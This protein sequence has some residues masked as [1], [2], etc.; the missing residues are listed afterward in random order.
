VP[1]HRLPKSPSATYSWD[2]ETN[3]FT[4][5]TPHADLAYSDGAA[6]EERLL[7]LV[8]GAADRSLHSAE[9]AAAIEDWPTRYHLHAGRANLLRPLAARLAGRTLEIGAGCG[10]LTRY[11]GEL[12]GDV[13]AVEGSRLRA[14]IAAA[15]CLDLPNVAVVH[16]LAERFVAD[17][18]FSAVTLVGVLEWATRFGDGADGAR[19][20]LAHVAT[21]LDPDGTL[22]VAIENQ[23]G[24]KYMAGWPEDHLG[25]PMRGVDD[26]YRP[27]EPRTYGIGELSALL[28]SAGLTRQ[29]VF[30][31][32]PDYK[33]PRVV[34]SPRG[35]ADAQWAS[36]LAGLVS[37]TPASDPQSPVFPVFSLEQSLALAAR[38]GVLTG[39]ANSFLV[40]ASRAPVA[41]ADESEVLTWHFSGGR[42]PAFQTETRF[43]ATAAGIA[44]ERVPMA[45][46]TTPPAHAPIRQAQDATDFV[47]GQLW[48]E[49][50]GP[51]IN[52][53][54]WTVAEVAAWSEP[55]RRAL[56]AAAGLTGES[57]DAV[58]P[59]RLLDATPFN[60]AGPDDRLGF[61]DLEWEPAWPVEYGFVVFRGLFWSLARLRSI[62]SGAANTPIGV[63]ALTLEVLRVAG[64]L[65]TDAEAERYLDLEAALQEQTSTV[66]ASAA[67]AALASMMVLPRPPLS[68]VA[69]AAGQHFRLQARATALEQ[70]WTK[71]ETYAKH[72]EQRYG[73]SESLSRNLEQQLAGMERDLEAVTAQRDESWEKVDRLEEGNARLARQLAEVETAHRD[74]A[75]QLRTVSGKC[76]NL[77]NDLA[78]ARALEHETAAKLQAREH[79]LR[80]ER[81]ALERTRIETASAN[82]RMRRLAAAQGHAR[83]AD[84]TSPASRVRQRL[85]DAD[86]PLGMLVRHPARFARGVVRLRRQG[87]RALVAQLAESGLFDR[88]HYRR[89]SGAGPHVN[90][91][92]R[93]LLGGDLAGES[94]HPLFDPSWYRA[95]YPDLD[96]T[97]PPLRHYLSAGGWELRIP[98]PLFDPAHYLAQWP[99][100]G[101]RA[102]TPLSHYVL[103]GARAAASPHPLFDT[104][105]YL[106]QRPELADAGVDPLAH[107]LAHGAEEGLDP[108]PLFSTRHY[109][110]RYPEVGSANPLA[111]FIERGAANGC[112]PHPLFD[113]AFYWEQRP[114]VRHHG[115][116]ALMHFLEFGGFEGVQPHPLFDTA[117]YHEQ[118][119]GLQV[120]GLN[121][122]VH[123]LQWGWQDGVWPNRYFDPQWYLA[124]N[125][126]LGD[127]NPLLHFLAHGWR[128]HRAPS[129]AFSV[130]AYLAANPDVEQADVNPLEH[131][132]RYGS[133]EGRRAVPVVRA[134]RVTADIGR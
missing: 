36:S 51:I 88:E 68:E 5:T 20:L 18:T 40:V 129:P 14:R 66:A 21:L 79:T 73:E 117:F 52:R 100:A 70:Q 126:D 132:L 75:N 86:L 6:L 4:P 131:F 112:S 45:P 49:R 95:R 15:R 10:V 26:S 90:L 25:E 103:V 89:A 134:R 105:H 94:S 57:L 128:E 19:R 109:Q 78:T 82:T 96:S 1:S 72:V 119:E 28:T 98:H 122:L 64:L 54:G 110:A 104:R 7:G 38:N 67:R 124:E 12:G 16:D 32:L 116:N 120:L 125:P 44:V 108:H 87:Y 106:R 113:T 39:V 121:P 9:L 48:I 80:I 31:A 93:F 58:L 62:A 130:A 17:A 107:Y 115:G 43:R 127:L 111:H 37:G 114:D 102:V 71:L 41:G 46:G 42:R 23:L 27:G 85:R 63:Q 69:D 76:D 74:T 13:V 118:A 35:L 47:E 34:V 29:A 91:V 2:A 92:A 77:A 55:W 83:T 50:L 24:L 60:L 59:A 11:L 53:P 61:F 81:R 30:A 3:L 22:I 56:Q 101:V 84:D 123:F 33:F 8:S 133:S 97:M 99:A 65:V